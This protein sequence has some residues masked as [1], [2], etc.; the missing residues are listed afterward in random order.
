MKSNIEIPKISS[1]GVT[2]CQIMLFIIIFYFFFCF[3][4]CILKV[5]FRALHFNDQI[6]GLH[7]ILTKIP[8]KHLAFVLN[9]KTV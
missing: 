2:A 9:K 3:F 6:S 5:L 4:F 8:V 1:A 7:K